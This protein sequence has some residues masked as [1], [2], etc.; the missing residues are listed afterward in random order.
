M[1]SMASKIYDIFSNF[2]KLN[3]NTGKVYEISEN[4]RNR[5]TV[6]FSG[7][8]YSPIP[9]SA[10]PEEPNQTLIKSLVTKQFIKKLKEKNFRAFMMSSTSKS[11]F[12][13]SE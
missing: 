5:D 13:H 9:M 2:F 3:I 7:K 1:K 12:R 6:F 10:K 8:H 4:Q 11:P